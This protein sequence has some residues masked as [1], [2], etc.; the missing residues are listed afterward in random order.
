MSATDRRVVAP[1]PFVRD[2]TVSPAAAPTLRREPG[3]AERD[4]RTHRARQRR[5]ETALAWGVPVVLVGAWQW[6]AATERISPLFFPAPTDVL[7]TASDMAASGELQHHLAATA[8]R[9]AL[10]LLVGVASGVIVGFAMGTSRLLRAAL[11]PTLSALYVVPKLALLPLLLLIFGVGD[12]PTIL[13]VAIAVFF[14]VWITTMHAVMSVPEG[15]REAARS[16]GAGR[17]Q[18]I[19]HVLLPA[20][21]PQ[22]LTGLRLATGMAVLT[23]VGIE[24]VQGS[25]G[26]GRLIWLSWSLFLPRRM[27]VGIVV[28]ALLGVAMHLLVRLL[29][30]L[31]TPWN[32]SNDGAP[33]M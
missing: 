11:D 18:L 6:A 21:L 22:I 5:R 1:T 28:V 3:P 14:L 9:I 2:E 31:L 19:R 16:F 17:G 7:A 13:L 29:A 10:G 24:F 15:W 32:R 25:D 33:T 20:S 27:Y 26:L 12:T 4:R 23:T 30:R 8:G